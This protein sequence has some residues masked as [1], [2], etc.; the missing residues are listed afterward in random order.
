[1]FV[2]LGILNLLFLIQI[3]FKIFE[4]YLVKL[5]DKIDPIRDQILSRK[6][7]IIYQYPSLR[8]FLKN[9]KRTTERVNELWCILRSYT[10]E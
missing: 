9:K 7:N 8:Q 10:K 4:G 6:P 1:M 2:L 3:V 5:S